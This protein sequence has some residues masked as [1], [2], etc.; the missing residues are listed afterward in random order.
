[1]VINIVSWIKIKMDF[2]I[3]RLMFLELLVTLMR[4]IWELV[5]NKKS[6]IVYISIK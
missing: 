6:I 4:N 2:A 1:M 3:L 5:R